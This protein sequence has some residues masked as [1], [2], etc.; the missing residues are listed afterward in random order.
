MPDA[1]PLNRFRGLL[2]A[3]RQG[4]REALGEL[5]GLFR[6][7][8]L[9]IADDELGAELQA[10]GSGADVVQDAFLE[11]QQLLDRF[12]GEGPEELRAWLRAVLLNKLREFRQR[13]HRA[14]SRQVGR[15]TSLEGASESLLDDTATPSSAAAHREQ[16]EQVIGAVARLP[17]D[18]QN[19]LRW[20]SWE[21]LSFA[22]IGQRLGRSEDAA[23]MLWARAIERLQRE[24][25]G[26]SP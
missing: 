25:E 6:T 8:L 9:A 18:Y 15:E 21:G 12:Q 26:H 23:R 10:K 22:Q 3:S 2:A 17:E 24:L 11:A 13:Y 19:V 20:R 7:Y 5:F 14:R 4:S 16:V 1:V